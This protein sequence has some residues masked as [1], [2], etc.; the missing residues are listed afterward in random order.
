MGQ[1][2]DVP[3]ARSWRAHALAR[4]RGAAGA[5]LSHA[6]GRS[7]SRRGLRARFPVGARARNRRAGARREVCAAACARGFVAACVPSCL[8]RRMAPEHRLREARFRDGALAARR[9]LSAGRARVAVAARA[10]RGGPQRSVAARRGRA[11]PRLLPRRS[12]VL[13]VRLRRCDRRRSVPGLAALHADRRRTGADDCRRARGSRRASGPY[14]LA[15]ARG[16][17]RGADAAGPA[18]K[19]RSADSPRQRR[20]LGVGRGG[21]R[22]A[23]R[24]R[25]RRPAAAAR[26]RSRRCGAVLLP[27]AGARHARALGSFPGATPA[28]GVRDGRPRPRTR[29]W[30][31]RAFPRAGSRALLPACRGAGSVFSQR[32][33]DAAQ[34][35][36][37][38]PLSPDPAR[39]QRAPPCANTDLGARRGWPHR[40]RAEPSERRGSGLVRDRF[41]GQRGRAGAG[42]RA[43]R[44]RRAGLAGGC[45]GAVSRARALAGDSHRC[46]FHT[47]RVRR[48]GKHASVAHARGKSGVRARGG[49]R[50]R[51][52]RA[53]PR[54]AIRRRLRA[55]EPP[56]RAVAARGGGPG[57]S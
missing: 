33:R 5:R 37:R 26:R 1:R 42:G 56:L 52:R 43:A 54:R 16:L 32:Q 39:R 50:F 6:T 38:G 27:L 15:R 12:P 53:S 51:G 14:A 36:L 17:A 19:P 41:P 23:A 31:L 34:S 24:Q 8:L 10:A 3:V 40:Y 20:A 9:E 48:A 30:R 18:P 13:L 7:A 47:A 35:T 44:A 55:R 21:G 29:Q 46:G 49:R 28:A 11:A 2:A 57:S 25:L 45:G 22:A 4:A